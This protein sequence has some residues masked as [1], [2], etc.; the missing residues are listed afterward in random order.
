LPYLRRQK[1]GE[2]DVLL[3]IRVFRIHWRFR[4]NGILGVCAPRRIFLSLIHGS[5]G[6]SEAKHEPVIPST[7]TQERNMSI[8]IV[9]S[10]VIVY[11]FL[12]A[13]VLP[14]LGV[15]T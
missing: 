3:F 13:Y 14:K 2:I 1:N 5:R 11:I 9:L 7:R 15:S 8:W 4:R 6:L 12:Q 10:V